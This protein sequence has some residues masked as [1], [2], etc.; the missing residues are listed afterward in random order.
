MECQDVRS[1]FGVCWPVQATALWIGLAVALAGCSA[2]EPPPTYPCKHP[3]PAHLGPD[4]QSDPCHFEDPD[5]PAQAVKTFFG[6]VTGPFCDALYAC[7]ADPVFLRDFAGGTVDAC[8]ALWADGTG[9][10][11][12]TLLALKRA[13][14]DGTTVFDAAQLD[15]CIAQ[16]NA[17]LMSPPAGSVACLEPAAN[18]LLNAC[19]S[20]AF[21][22]QIATG[23][24]C[25]PWPVTPED[26]SFAECQHG[27]CVGGKCVAFLKS[28]DICPLF[29]HASDPPDTICDFLH[30]E[31]CDG[32]SVTGTCVSRRELGGACDL[33]SGYLCKSLTC[34]QQDY[35]CEPVNPEST[36]CDVF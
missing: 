27:R 34:S 11:S 8:K 3:D 9:L 1:S 26:L 25:V 12:E 13:L 22:P 33:D 15:A 28:G 20:T 17:R 30:G 32:S 18:L 36:G 31:W 19:L 6:A 5:S 7:C 29:G 23:A 2:P 21:Q 10:G 24:A 4:G 35:I 14:V 16:L